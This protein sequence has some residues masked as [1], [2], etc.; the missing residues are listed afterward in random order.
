VQVR[1]MQELYDRTGR[2]PFEAE[3]GMPSLRSAEKLTLPQSLFQPAYRTAV[4]TIDQAMSCLRG[5]RPCLA[6][7]PSNVR[8]R[9][10]IAPSR[11][12]SE[13]AAMWAKC[14]PSK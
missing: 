1:H 2:R 12:R 4:V 5:S 9:S 7:A 13:K 8:R 10:R 11:L 14:A 3:L 6:R